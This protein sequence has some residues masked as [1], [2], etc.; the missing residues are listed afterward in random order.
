MSIKK[1]FGHISFILGFLQDSRSWILFPERVNFYSSND[2]KEFTLIDGLD[3]HNQPTDNEVK[4]VKFKKQ[5]PFP[6]SRVWQEM[7]KGKKC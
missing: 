5:F 7:N 4:I 3:N 6:F 1:E 2:N